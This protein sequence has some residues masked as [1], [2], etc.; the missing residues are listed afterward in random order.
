MNNNYMHP[1]NSDHER[2]AEEFSNR[3]ILIRHW[4]MFIAFV[5]ASQ[6]EAHRMEARKSL[7]ATSYYR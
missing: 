2:R 3:Q 5:K 7:L 1:V 6:L 4:N